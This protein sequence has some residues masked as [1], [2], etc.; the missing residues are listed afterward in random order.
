MA[1]SDM[2][3]MLKRRMAA[4]Q[5]ASELQIGDSAY[6]KLFQPVAPPPK[7]NICELPIE[8]LVPFFTVDI[9]FKPYSIE[10]LRAFSK[11]LAAEGLFERVI[12]R[13]IPHHDRFEILAGHNRTMAGAMAGWTTIPCE[14]VEADDDR[15][16][17]IAIATNLLR[18]Q[19]LTI[20]ERGKAYKALLEAKNRNGQRN[21][22]EET[23]GD[24]RQRYNARQ[25]VADFFGVTEYEIRKA[26]KLTQLI[27]K[28]QDI[29]ENDPKKL[30]L[31]CA[32]LIADYDQESQEAFIEMCSI[33]GYQLNKGTM[34]HI[35]TK[36]PPPYAEKSSLYA[37]WREAR[38]SA[39]KRMSEPPRKITFDRKKF[40]PYLD[41]LGSDKE[42]ET[43]FLE[44]L[45]ERVV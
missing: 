40:A 34:R 15:A 33:E 10:K 3:A 25:I 19:E 16:T 12:V 37:A 29:L 35:I 30:N 23:F 41:K 11:Q 22:A 4:T 13:R 18:R 14:I 32:E 45:R 9:G 8:K 26:V 6:E 21:A 7:S 42:L 5:Q 36:C 28:L 39:E 20:I 31:A 27:P 17:S 2:N 24:N 43:L 1:K 44:F 38:A